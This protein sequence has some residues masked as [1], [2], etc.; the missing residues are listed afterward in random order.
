MKRKKTAPSPRTAAALAAICAA[1]VLLSL[2]FALRVQ[3]WK[4][5]DERAHF[6]YVEHLATHRSFP[7]LKSKA[8][9]SLYEAHQPPAYYVLAVPVYLLSRS[10]GEVRAMYALR[11]WTCLFGAGTLG[12]LWWLASTLFPRRPVLSLSAVAFVGLLP[13]HLYVASSLGNDALAGMIATATLALLVRSLRTP[14][15]PRTALLLGALVGLGLLS[16][17]TCLFLAPLVA[18]RFLWLEAGRRATFRQWSAN[19]LAAGAAALAVS[20]WWLGRNTLLYGD[21]LVLRKFNEVFVSSPHPSKF[22]VD[23]GMS[24]GNYLRF[25]AQLVFLT[26]WGVLGEVNDAIRRLTAIYRGDLSWDGTVGLALCAVFALATVLA[27][28]GAGMLWPEDNRDPETRPGLV[29]VFVGLGLVVLSFVQFN[30]AYFQAQ[31]RYL[32][33]LVCGVALCFAAAPERLPTAWAQWGAR[34]LLAGGM[35]TAAAMDLTVWR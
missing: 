34:I 26:F 14:P 18:A 9:S 29:L 20:G 7:V 23:Y 25:V 4:Q 33:P 32:H 5:P 6:Q 27:A 12:F 13:M 8:E 3:P 17:T 31:A 2:L 30:F 1:S 22:L 21:P 16:K 35:L 15:A 28:L 11:V 19:T 10:G 24:L